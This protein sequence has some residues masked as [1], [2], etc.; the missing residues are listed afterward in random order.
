ML[1]VSA[2]VSRIKPYVPPT[3]RT[4]LRKLKGMLT[5]S[6]G[7]FSRMESELRIFSAA[8]D[9]HRLP[10][11][12][13]YWFE[14]HIEPVLKPFGVRNSIEMFRTYIARAC[15]AAPLGTCRIL[16]IAAGDCAPEINIAEWLREN[17]IQN[18][19]FECLDLNPDVLDRARQAAA[20]KGLLAHFE[21]R[22]AD[23]NR[24]KPVQLYDVVLAIQCLHH[25][26]RLESIFEKLH[27]ALHPAG[28]FMTDD[29]IGRNGHR[30][31]PEAKV[32]VDRFWEELP[33]RHKYNHAFK[34]QDKSPDDRDFSVD[35]FE[36]IRSQDILRL[37][38]ERFHFD[39]F[40]A[41]ANVI[42]VFVDRTYG[43]NFDPSSES[44]RDFIDR[45]HA[46][47]E[48]E[49]DCGH[50]KP[51]HIYA[52]MTKGSLRPPQFHRHWSPEFC[53]RPVERGK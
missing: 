6:S 20:T 13:S 42:D 45:V 25:F 3:L 22:N 15:K 37:L 27:R 16:T 39:L 29:M 7:Q 24:W 44:D 5:G 51:T 8:E 34:T 12:S 43:P 26:T 10:S 11:I 32:H 2:V 19:H 31:W 4:Q 1:K 52:A 36:G 48:H 35:S 49:I 28:F 14:K 50:I 23:I 17:S 30:R 33:D 21:F 47:D 53:I 38:V 46:F 9:I 18:F 41:F 40:I